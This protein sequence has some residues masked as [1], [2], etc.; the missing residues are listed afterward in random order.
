MT[1]FSQIWVNEVPNNTEISFSDK[2]FPSNVSV[3]N[4]K[5]NWV[6]LAE[7]CKLMFTDSISNF[8]DCELP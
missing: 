8:K 7:F 5:M 4:N 1:K 3:S 6:P 2:Q